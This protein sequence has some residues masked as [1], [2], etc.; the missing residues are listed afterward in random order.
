MAER[1][2]A[3][4]EAVSNPER[5]KAFL[6]LGRPLSIESDE[7]TATQKVR[8]RHV[9]SRFER[10]FESLYATRPDRGAAED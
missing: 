1:V 9:V 5:V 7:L 4:M 6:L 3:I 8:R 2:A 10:E